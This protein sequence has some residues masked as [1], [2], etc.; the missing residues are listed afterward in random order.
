M[1][2]IVYTEY[3]PPEVLQLREVVKPVPKDNEALIRIAATTVASEDCLFRQ[4]RP[5][6]SRSATG[7]FKPKYSV[8]GNSIAGEVEAVGKQ[9][10][11]FKAGDQVYGATNADFGAYAEYKCLPEDGALAIKPASISA[12][13]AVAISSGALTALP[14]LRDTGEIRS[15]QQV[16]IN[17]ASGSV[18]T[19]AIQLAKHFGA[20][21]TGV[22]GTANI[23]LVKALGAD[24]VIDYRNED[25][26][27]TREGWDIIFDAVGKS[28]FGSC[29]RALKP[30]G[31]YLMPVLNAAIVCQMLWTSSF[32]GK[33]AKITFTGLR[34]TAEKTKDLEFLN[35][36]IEAGK[37]KPVIDKRYPLAQVAEAH[38][39]VEQGH[40]KGNV[41][42]TVGD[43]SQ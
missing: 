13:D 11:R 23:D 42:I 37:L 27:K 32:G 2:A 18:G 38:R 39:Y 9:V 33:K 16:L 10:K 19:A 12:G 36:L 21:V 5:L 28:S 41:V 40:K 22:C 3:G 29:K 8:L 43:S 4:G 30:H 26:T 24:R 34:S 17:G 20:E 31:V 7:L 6:I 35:T 1:N 25:F 14:F 15:G